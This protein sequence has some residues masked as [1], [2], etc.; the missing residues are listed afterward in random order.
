M[1]LVL[2][3]QTPKQAAAALAALDLPVKHV[4]L[5]GLNGTKDPELF[6]ILR[7]RDWILISDDREMRKKPQ[8]RAGI[9]ASGVGVYAFTGTRFKNARVLTLLLLKMWDELFEDASTRKRPFIMQITDQCSIK[10]F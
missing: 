5:E 1:I 8:E 7:D 4:I 6:K 9:V 3:E 10:P 2:D